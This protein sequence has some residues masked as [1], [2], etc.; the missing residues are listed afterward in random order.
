MGVATKEK[1]RVLRAKANLTQAELAKKAEITSRSIGLYEAD[2][3][4]LRKAQYVTL[5]KIADALNVT[6]DDIFLG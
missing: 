3:N 4:N 1:L 6:V 2:I 5:E